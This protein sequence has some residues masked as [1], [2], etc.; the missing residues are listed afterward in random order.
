LNKGVFTKTTLPIV[1]L[2]F[3]LLQDFFLRKM[4]GTRFGFVGTRYFLILGTRI[5]SPKRLTKPALLAVETYNLS[6][7]L[8]TKKPQLHYPASRTSFSAPLRHAE[9]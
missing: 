8:P 9:K 1:W 6:S 3:T 7:K 4:L 2:L 5:G